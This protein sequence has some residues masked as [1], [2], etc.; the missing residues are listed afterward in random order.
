[1]AK[2]PKG[3]IIATGIFAPDIGGPAS[4]ATTLAT[5]LAVSQPVTVVTYS[6]VWH[7]R[8]DINLPFKVVRIWS[9][10]PKGIKHIIFLFKIAA[11][12]RKSHLV[13][14]LNA[15]SAGFPARLAARFYNKKFVVKIVGDSAWERAINR[16]KTSLMLND[17]QKSKHKGWIRFLHIAQFQICK[18][19]H[20]VIVPSEYLAGIVKG[21]GILPEKIK[22]IYNGVDF[23]PSELSKE[24]ARRKLAL[25]GNII[26]SWGRIV[27]WKGF[28][29]LIKIM[30]RLAEI[31]QF[32]QLVI[33]G[34]GPDR[35]VLEAMVKNLGLG[36]KVIIAGK[37][38]HKEI[39]DYLAAS[40]MVVLNSGYEGFSHQV[41]EA[42]TAGVPVITSSSG[43]NREII[44]QGENGFMIKYNDEFN[45][46]EAIRTL[47]NNPETREHFVEEGK[48]TV[49]YFTAEKMFKE[50][51][52]LLTN[53]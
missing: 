41:L 14:A 23:K 26:F 40:D 24:E 51:M 37:K 29:M 16:G 13:L 52:T 4:Y 46:I 28:R 18:G 11:Q 48:K 6:S 39:A 1:M 3:I 12:V 8:D 50:T 30:P 5:R 2:H 49:E 7:S 32:F 27:P 47:W 45:I 44:H 22:V 10:W 34:D 9:R 25:T 53:V 43:G 20:A 21:W 42:M 35:T 38:T 17:F 36:R 33:V 19:A 15:V 31:N